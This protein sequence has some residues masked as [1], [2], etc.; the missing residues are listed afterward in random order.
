MRSPSWVGQGNTVTPRT[1]AQNKHVYWNSDQL[2][3]EM[4]SV[5]SDG[6]PRILIRD[7]PCNLLITGGLY[8]L[9][10]AT[11]ASSSAGGLLPWDAAENELI[12]QLLA[13]EQGRE[14]TWSSF[15]SPPDIRVPENNFCKFLGAP[16]KA[17]LQHLN[18]LGLRWGLRKVHF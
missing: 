18:P 7:P 15:Q 1:R 6:F 8:K 12:Q 4:G 9:E 17:V 5:F 13:W 16:P 14:M 11:W 3:S 2:T 10:R